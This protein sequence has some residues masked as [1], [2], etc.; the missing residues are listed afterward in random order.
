[1][2]INKLCAFLPIL[3]LAA[4]AMTR[5]DDVPDLTT[6]LRE[7]TGQ[8]GRACVRNS[9]IRG[10]GM[11]RSK[12]DD[13]INIDATPDYYIATVRPGCLDLQTSMGIIFSGSI[14]EVCGG[15]IDKVITQG[16]ECSIN[17]IFRFENRDQAF[18]AFQNAVD[19]RQEILDKISH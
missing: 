8:N 2:K 7:T 15:R 6:M 18:E 14:N 11:Q 17:Q 16:N 19:R 9:D 1:M 3:L 13:A 4:C 5:Q 10:Y 12:G